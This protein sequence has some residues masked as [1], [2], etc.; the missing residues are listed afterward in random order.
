MRRLLWPD[1]V[2]D[3]D[4]LAAVW[5]GAGMR[6]LLWAPVAADPEVANVLGFTR[7]GRRG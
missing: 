4:R 5:E 1:P 2:D 7:Q 3:L 6:R